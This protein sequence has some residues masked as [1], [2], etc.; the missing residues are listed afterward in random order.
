M[1][2]GVEYDDQRIVE[3]NR[4]ERHEPR[5]VADTHLLCGHELAYKGVIGLRAGHEPEVGS[6]GLLSRS[7]ATGLE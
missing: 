3:A 7:L 1:L 5:A 2:L 6:F 4:H